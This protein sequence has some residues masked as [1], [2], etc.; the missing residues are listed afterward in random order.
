MNNFKKQQPRQINNEN[1]EENELSISFEAIELDERAQREQSTQT[2]IVFQDMSTQTDSFTRERFTQ[3]DPK[4]GAK[5]SINSC[6]I[7]LIKLANLVD[8]LRN[9]MEGWNYKSER[10]FGTVI[11]MILRH[12][13]IGRAKIEHVLNAF[14]CLNTK[15]TRRWALTMLEEDDQSIILLD[16]RGG[17]KQPQLYAQYPEIEIEAKA[18]AITETSE[19]NSMFTVKKL[20]AFVNA[21]FQELSDE[22][23][24]ANE[25]I[26][27]NSSLRLDL[28]RWGAKWTK[29]GKKTYFI[30]HEREDVV[31]HRNKLLRY[32][33]EN[34][35]RF[36]QQTA[37]DEMEWVPPSE[38]KPITIICHDE[39]TFNAGDQQ[40]HKWSFGFNSA[41]YDKNRGRS[42]MLSYFLCQHPFVS[43]FELSDDEMKDAL[44]KYPEL[45]SQDS[46]FVCDKNSANASMEPGKNKDGYFDNVTI[47]KQF[48]RLFKMLEFKTVFKNTEKVIFID[49][50][51]THSA[52]KYD[53][54]LLFKKSGTNCPYESLEWI[55]DGETKTVSFFFDERK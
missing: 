32:L 30:G 24:D 29:N 53:K 3:T 2:N 4:V 12:F 21:R 42:R 20:S 18:Y 1:I 48:E 15:T 47:L 28:C 7:E 39:S 14:D 26:R 34:Q 43:L 52:K 38:D 27:S 45:D 31:D 8:C 22:N 9:S 46:E 41:I 25:S 51:R 5:S 44:K 17:Y 50:A 37:A 40:S 19:R 55:E 13:D 49:N 11:Y 6:E 33:I 35:S 36:Y 23:L 10:I 54:T 16:K